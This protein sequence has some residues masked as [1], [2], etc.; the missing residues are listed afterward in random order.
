MHFIQP[1]FIGPWPLCQNRLLGLSLLLTK[2]SLDELNHKAFQ[3][4]CRSQCQNTCLSAC[5]VTRVER[6]LS[7]LNA[8]GRDHAPAN[9]ATNGAT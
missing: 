5:A 1:D 4:H 3:R 8:L 7:R 9:T 6:F 2:T